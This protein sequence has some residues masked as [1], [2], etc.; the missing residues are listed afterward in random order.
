MQHPESHLWSQGI[1]DS[2]QEAK[3]TVLLA[4]LVL[5]Q[6]EIASLRTTLK[7]NPMHSTS[8][9]GKLRITVVNLAISERFYFTQIN[10]IVYIGSLETSTTLTR[11]DQLQ[12]IS[13][14]EV[15]SRFQLQT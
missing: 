14:V 4:E 2:F 12:A 8:T 6:A 15:P 3:E 5:N 11:R 1:Q 10:L 7:D 9:K 13:S